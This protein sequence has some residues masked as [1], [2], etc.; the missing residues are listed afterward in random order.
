M[1]CLKLFWNA[2]LEFLSETVNIDNALF[3]FFLL[4]IILFVPAL[5][6]CFHIPDCYRSVPVFVPGRSSVS[7]GTDFFGH[8]FHNREGLERFD[9][10]SEMRRIG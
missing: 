6:L 8:D 5:L 1:K 2:H 4:Y 7:I 10:E 3:R 9:S